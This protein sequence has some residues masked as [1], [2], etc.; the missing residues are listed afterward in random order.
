V[1]LETKKVIR[2][3]GGSSASGARPQTSDVKMHLD[4][5]HDDEKSKSFEN[6]I[7]FISDVGKSGV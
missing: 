6:A 2:G 5:N 1:R 3:W 7:R 4:M